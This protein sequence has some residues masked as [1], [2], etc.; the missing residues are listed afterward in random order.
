MGINRDRDDGIESGRDRPLVAVSVTASGHD[1]IMQHPRWVLMDAAQSDL[2]RWTHPSGAREGTRV[3]DEEMA[4]LYRP[5]V[6]IEG[7]GACLPDD[8]EPGDLPPVDDATVDLYADFLPDKADPTAATQRW[9]AVVD[10]RGLIRWPPTPPTGDDGRDLLVL[11]C[12]S[13]PPRYL[14]HLRRSRIAYL[15]A[16]ADDV[17]LAAVFKRMAERLGVTR[18]VAKTGGGLTGALLRAE[19]VD[20]VQVVTVEVDG[21][22]GTATEF[23]GPPRYDGVLPHSL[24]LV[25][26]H[27]TPERGL[28]LRYDSG[29]GQP[30]RLESSS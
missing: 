2:W 7:T 26:A 15:V 22:R 19:L 4:R 11:A 14:A 1:R 16:G 20:E 5:E 8:A 29:D 3:R 21:E 25:A 24:R 18:V 30:V 17:D 10:G 12:R 13:T 6:V 28:W 9:A 23:A 27:S